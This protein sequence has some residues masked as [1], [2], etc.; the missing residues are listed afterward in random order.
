MAYGGCG[1][2]STSRAVTLPSA[3]RCSYVTVTASTEIG[4]EESRG[5]LVTEHNSASRKP[6]P[7]SDEAIAMGCKCPVMDNNHGKWAPW[8]P[9]G[10]W[11]N[12]KCLVHPVKEREDESSE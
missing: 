3:L 10:W 5:C 2:T 6:N 9:D 7:G 1:S 8:P 4:G 12:G 11:N